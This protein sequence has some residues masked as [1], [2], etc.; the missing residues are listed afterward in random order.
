MDKL[1]G[2]EE[3]RAMVAW[4]NGQDENLWLRERNSPSIE[5]IL[6]AYRLA[7]GAHVDTFLAEIGTMW[8]RAKLRR[9]LN[10]RG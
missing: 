10:L 3:L 6:A 2:I 1:E 8:Q 7:E 5:N 4:C 9:L